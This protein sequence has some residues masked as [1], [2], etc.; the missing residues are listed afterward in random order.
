MKKNLGIIGASYLQLPL[1]E[2]AKK[3]GY[4]TH[5]F[6]WAADDYGEKAADFFYPISIIEKE[7]IVEKC[8]SIGIEGICSIA[9]DLA[10]VTVNYVAN[11][12]G[13]I[14]NSME[15]T[16]KSTNKYLMR[17]AF[18]ENGDP[19]PVSIEVD[20]HTDITKLEFEYPVIVKPTDRSGSRGVRKIENEIQ[21][22]D[23][24][25]TA[26]SLSFEKKCVIEEFV[27]G[28]EYSIEAISYRGHHSILA[29]TKKY[30]TGA[31]YFIETAH[32]E[33][34]PIDDDLKKKHI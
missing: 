7:Q 4:T 29:I 22:N 11:R 23:A 12:L 34:A 3:M 20:D 8:K 9:S 5:V 16:I 6:A 21:L 25:N 18:E 24:I 28:D 17:K 26:I 31:P 14:G 1:I 15:C 13:L 19:S 27:E 33:P 10:S 32:V 30:T 2:K